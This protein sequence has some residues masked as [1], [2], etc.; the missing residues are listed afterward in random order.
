VNNFIKNGSHFVPEEKRSNEMQ[1]QKSN[2][3]LIIAMI[4]RNAMSFMAK[5]PQNVGDFLNDYYSY[6]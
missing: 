1:R 3:K 4:A 6:W 2:L 5:K